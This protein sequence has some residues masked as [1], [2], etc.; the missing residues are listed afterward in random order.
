MSVS[1]SNVSDSPVTLTFGG[2]EFDLA[3]FR[4]RVL[5][6]RWSQGVAFPAV[7]TTL[8]LQPGES[9]TYTATWDQ[10]DLLGQ[11]VAAGDYALV[12]AIMPLATPGQA[13]LRPL[14]SRPYPFA[15]TPAPTPLG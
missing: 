12:G 6:W 13:D 10:K 1:V 11:P 5:V 4:D 3:V 2:Q 14:R 8:T 9:K 7:V 15:I